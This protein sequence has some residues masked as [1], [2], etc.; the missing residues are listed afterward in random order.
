MPSLDFGQIGYE[1]YGKTAG[2]KT[3]DG[4][5]MPSWEEAG[6]ETRR[7]WHVAAHGILDAYAHAREDSERSGEALTMTDEM[8]ADIR[9]HHDD[10][11]VG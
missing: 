7:R 10:A 3:F 2:W 11:P 9:R 6:D 4:R 8:R 1:A 5:R